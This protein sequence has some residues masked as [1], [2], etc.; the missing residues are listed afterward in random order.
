MSNEELALIIQAGDR[1]QLPALWEQTHL[2]CYKIIHRYTDAAASNVAVSIEDLKQ[3]C[4]IAMVDA[5]GH[6]NP[7]LGG[8]LNILNFYV[9]K[10]CRAAL[11]LLG[12]TRNEHY[13]KLPL[14]APLR[15]GDTMTLADVLEDDTLPGMT[16][17]LERE[18]LQRD[19]REAVARLPF[20]DDEI[21]RRYYF[22]GAS[23]KALADERGVTACR[24]QQRKLDA[25]ERLRSDQRLQEYAEINFY[26]HK[27]VKAFRESGSSVVEDLVLQMEAAQ[28]RRQAQLDKQIQEMREEMIAYA[29]GRPSPRRTPPATGST[30]GEMPG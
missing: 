16:D 28:E 24:I 29:W 12:R 26:R 23:I 9:R 15:D 5:V 6:F 14:D 4:Y 17:E 30:G 11:G 2:F 20:G 8:F 19:V 27:G 10:H 18:E 13:Y 3:E 25:L 1:E 7:D 21:M 22:E